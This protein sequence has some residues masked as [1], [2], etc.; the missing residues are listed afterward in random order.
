MQLLPISL[1]TP[2]WHAPSEEWHP[3]CTMSESSEAIMLKKPSA[4]FPTDN[5]TKGVLQHP[6]FPAISEGEFPAPAV[7]APSCESHLLLFKSPQAFQGTQ[8]KAQTIPAMP[9]QKSQSAESMSIIKW[10]YTPLH[11]EVGC[12]GSKSNWDKWQSKKMEKPVSLM[13]TPSSG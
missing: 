7:L 9:C 3:P 1:G 5:L 8:L 2:S 11:F 4:H 12:S 10:I 6:K 13:A